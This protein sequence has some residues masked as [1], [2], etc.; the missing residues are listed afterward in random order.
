MA[1]RPYEC[2]ARDFAYVKAL[3]PRE[4]LH[5][6]LSIS[7]SPFCESSNI[8]TPSRYEGPLFRRARGPR[9]ME[10]MVEENGSTVDPLSQGSQSGETAPTIVTSVPIILNTTCTTNQQTSAVTT[11]ATTTTATRHLLASTSIVQLTL[12]SAAAAQVYRMIRSC[13]SMHI[14][15]CCTCSRLILRLELFLFD[16]REHASRGTGTCLLETFA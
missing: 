8:Q 7:V 10:S 5:L 4:K 9:A 16:H 11:A 14:P 3:Q 15:C 1:L 6:S 2:V 13:V 12:P